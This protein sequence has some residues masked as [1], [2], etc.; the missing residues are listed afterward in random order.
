MPAPVVA[1]ADK[2]VRFVAKMCRVVAH[3]VFIIGTAFGG[4]MIVL[5]LMSLF[6]LI[7]AL[8]SSG[9]F[10][11]GAAVAAGFFVILVT[12]CGSAAILW[13]ASV[14]SVLAAIEFHT[15]KP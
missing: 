4:L 10:S 3:I 9:Q 6:I 14:L 2:E 8:G 15:R 13:F 12:L 5:G 1:L 11:A 7:P